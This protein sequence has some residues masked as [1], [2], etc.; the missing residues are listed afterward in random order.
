MLVVVDNKSIRIRT[1]LAMRLAQ[2]GCTAF[3]DPRVGET[4]GLDRLHRLAVARADLPFV[5]L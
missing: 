5:E 3:L 4:N 2:E 1:T